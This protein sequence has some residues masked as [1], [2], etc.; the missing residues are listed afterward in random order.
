[1]KDYYYNITGN[2]VQVKSDNTT[3]LIPKKLK[4]FLSI[5][6]P[7]KSLDIVG[8][9]FIEWFENPVANCPNQTAGSK[10]DIRFN[11]LLNPGRNLLVP[12]NGEPIIVMSQGSKWNC[13]QQGASCKAL[14]KKL[15]GTE[16]ITWGCGCDRLDFDLRRD[17]EVFSNL[18]KIADI[19]AVFSYKTLQHP[20]FIS[21]TITGVIVL[22]IIL[23][24][25]EYPYTQFRLSRAA[26]RLKAFVV[27][28]FAT[29][30]FF[31][32]FIL[33][34]EDLSPRKLLMLYYTRV[35]METGFSSFFQLGTN[36][37]EL[38]FWDEFRLSFICSIITKTLVK[39]LAILMAYDPNSPNVTRTTATPG[40]VH[41]IGAYQRLRVFFGGVVACGI[42]CLAYYCIIAIS[43]QSEPDVIETWARMTVFSVLQ[44]QILTHAVQVTISMA[45]VNVMLAYPQFR[46]REKMIKVLIS[47]EIVAILETRLLRLRVATPSMT[48]K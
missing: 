31:G 17:I 8:F 3:V 32:I 48:S 36:Y 26:S 33:Q 12:A 18:K 15:Q 24:K 2:E 47:E 21:L 11:R 30:P 16:E 38:T 42:C 27:A 13:S 39:S 20:V 35:M 7:L 40:G 10:Y 23:F 41:Y 34:H 9:Q 45:F 4:P 43:L 25:E 28:L 22:A 44:D 5:V 1:M 6:S 46:Y 37:S 19:S 14:Q 29:H